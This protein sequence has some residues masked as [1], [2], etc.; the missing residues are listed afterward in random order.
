MCASASECG[1][2]TEQVRVHLD[3]KELNM[4]V[5][6]VLQCLPFV[7][8]GAPLVGHP[9]LQVSTLYANSVLRAVAPAV[10]TN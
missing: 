2:K 10:G 7:A 8:D 9:H 4:K 5:N 6:C 1:D 3:E